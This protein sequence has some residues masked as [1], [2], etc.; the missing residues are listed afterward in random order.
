M[1][2]SKWK[3]PDKVS[4][5]WM[6]VDRNDKITCIPYG[7]DHMVECVTI[8]KADYDR[9]VELIQSYENLSR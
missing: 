2:Q 5:S 7:A 1:S 6:Y 9:M 4:I 3:E 8:R